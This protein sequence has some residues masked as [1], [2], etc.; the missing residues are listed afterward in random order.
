MNNDM[1]N[2]IVKIVCFCVF[3]WNVVN[4]I[5]TGTAR[6]IYRKVSRE[7]E[8]GLF[9]AAVIVSALCGA[10]LA[11]ASLFPWVEKP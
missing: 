9:W 10:W 1:I 11:V 3:L 2:E 7:N 4:G 8:A 6:L 5:R